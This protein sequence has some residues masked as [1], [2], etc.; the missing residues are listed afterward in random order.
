M[1][2]ELDRLIEYSDEEILAEIRRVAGLVT[3][4]ILSKAE[5]ERH[6]PRVSV[7]TIQ[8]HFGSWS[9]ALERADLGH[10]SY[11]REQPTRGMSNGDLLDELR[12]IAREKGS[13]PI[14]ITD[15]RNGNRISVDT[16]RRRFG[17]WKKALDA[18]GLKQSKLGKRH[19]DDECFENLLTVWT[20]YGR[21]PMYREMKKPPSSV[22][23][24]AYVLRFGSWNRA[25]AA[26]V[27]RVNADTETPSQSD[28]APSQ[29]APIAAKTA[30]TR[31]PRPEDR[32]DVPLGLRFFVFK[33]DRFRCVV[34]GNSPAT[35]LHCKLH[36]D[37]IIPFSKGGKTV[38]ENLR[39]ACDKCNI[40][41]GN[42]YSD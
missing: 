37:H 11:I 36:A 10:R 34:C 32:R 41:R 25:L 23:G 5:F 8:T 40:G 38:A 22:G 26:F 28:A 4:P 16:L 18:A 35:D 12:A 7:N 15:L 14:L 33:R 1:K 31:S 21:P 19:T 20:H 42:R 13:N 3:S 27:A 17:S 2:F 6:A 9:N 30:A 29:A 39:A 24:K